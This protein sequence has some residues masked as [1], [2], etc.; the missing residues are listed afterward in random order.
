MGVKVN[1]AGDNGLEARFALEPVKEAPACTRIRGE[2]V[3]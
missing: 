3:W 2:S 1:A